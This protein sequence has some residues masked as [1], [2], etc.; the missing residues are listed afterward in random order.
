MKSLM[1]TLPL[2]LVMISLSGM[3]LLP[4]TVLSE[5]FN[6]QGW[7][8]GG[9]YDNHYRNE[10]RDKFKGVIVDIQEIIPMPGMS[11]GIGLVI[12]KRQ[13]GKHVLVHLGPKDFVLSRGHF[14]QKGISVKV[15]GVWA[16][17]GGREVFMA[18]KVKQFPDTQIKVRRTR[19]GKPFWSMPADELK[20]EEQYL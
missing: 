8:Q 3:L 11:T 2:F 7:E 19:D 12:A 6:T 14:L 5:K 16:E 15:Y 4:Q 10:E 9:E 13:S 17:I 1:R 18:A 20:R